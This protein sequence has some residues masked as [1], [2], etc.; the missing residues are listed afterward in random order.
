MSD[1]Q[2]EREKIGRRYEGGYLTRMEFIRLREGVN[3][4]E[5]AEIRRLAAAL[6]YKNEDR[7]P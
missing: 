3:R 2:S 6:K 4:R 5:R 1:F 7:A